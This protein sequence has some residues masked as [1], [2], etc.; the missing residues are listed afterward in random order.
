MVKLYRLMSDGTM[1][2]VDFGVPARAED[3]VMQGYIVM[4]PINYRVVEK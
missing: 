3:Y 2:F 4:Y 1:V